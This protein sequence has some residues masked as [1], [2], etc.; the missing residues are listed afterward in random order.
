MS[1]IDKLY[2]ALDNLS[3]YNKLCGKGNGDLSDTCYVCG[4][5]PTNLKALISTAVREARIDETKRW[6]PISPDPKNSWD[7]KFVEAGKARI[8]QLKEGVQDGI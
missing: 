7:M 1:D 5:S 2:D 4:I 8:A 6:M 3:V